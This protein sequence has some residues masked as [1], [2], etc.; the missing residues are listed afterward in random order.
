[1]PDI[2]ASAVCVSCH[3][4]DMSKLLMYKSPYY[5]PLKRDDGTPVMAVLIA[6]VTP[7]LNKEQHV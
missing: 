2:M 1:M 3:F 7:V 5:T 6:H 4:V